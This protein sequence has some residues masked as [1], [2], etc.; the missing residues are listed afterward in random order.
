MLREVT[1]ITKKTTLF[2]FYTKYIIMGDSIFGGKFRLQKLQKNKRQRNFV[3]FYYV[4]KKNTNGLKLCGSGSRPK[5][6][7][8]R[9][10][11]HG[12]HVSSS[13]SSL[14]F[15]SSCPGLN[16]CYR[17][18][19][20]KGYINFAAKNGFS[21]NLQCKITVMQYICIYIKIR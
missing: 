13:W 21:R 17:N 6:T 12:V 9:P 10:S 16:G 18:L 19:Q 3:I 7:M 5:V 11:T 14:C 4:F 1:A 8:C 2:N 15:V 20:N